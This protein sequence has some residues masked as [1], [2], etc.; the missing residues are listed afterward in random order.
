MKTYN[1]FAEEWIEK[2]EFK[3]A[4]A[5]FKLRTVID[6]IYPTTALEEAQWVVNELDLI[7][8][9]LEDKKTI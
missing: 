1:N 2:K 8:K 3:D 6:K 4:I 9:M 7:S 5:R